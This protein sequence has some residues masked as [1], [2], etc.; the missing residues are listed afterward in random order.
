M[1]DG[2]WTNYP[3]EGET[4]ER[5]KEQDLPEKRYCYQGK[6]V[7]NIKTL[8]N[9]FVQC[10]KNLADA[11][12]AFSTIKSNGIPDSTSSP[13]KEE[14]QEPSTPSTTIKPVN[15]PVAKPEFNTSK[16]TNQSLAT[17]VIDKDSTDSI[18]QGSDANSHA[19]KIT[20][21]D[22]QVL[23]ATTMPNGLYS[24]VAANL[25]IY[26]KGTKLLIT[27]PDGSMITRVVNDTGDFAKDN[28]YQLDVAWPNDHIPS[29]GVGIG[30]AK[31]V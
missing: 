17:P 4:V 6:K 27:L 31:V 11:L 26:P 24:G 21:Y 28:P 13:S 25:S 5:S 10:F 2:Y 8:W 12:I 9:N 19:V 7:I 20:F 22:P 16:D 1:E 29:Y 14:Q 3:R 23:G 18:K 15:N 30:T